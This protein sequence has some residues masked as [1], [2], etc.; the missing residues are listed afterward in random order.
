MLY[1][2]LLSSDYLMWGFSHGALF[3]DINVIFM[4]IKLKMIYV[5]IK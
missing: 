3:V 4:I 2:L 5:L 1:F